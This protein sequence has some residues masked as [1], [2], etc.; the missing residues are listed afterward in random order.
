MRYFI[1]LFAGVAMVY[2]TATAAE[3]SFTTHPENTWLKRSPRE[4]WRRRDFI[5]KAAARLIRSPISGFI[6]RRTTAF[7]KGFTRS[8]ATWRAARGRNGFR[9]R[10]RRAYAA[11]TARMCSTSRGSAS[12]VFPAG[13][14]GEWHQ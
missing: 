7:R 11:W 8:R 4:A 1:S 2:A 13:P 12:S 6:T 5:T 3:S 10:R 14:L 9:P